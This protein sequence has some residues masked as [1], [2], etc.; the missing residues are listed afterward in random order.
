[1]RAGVPV[2][3]VPLKE[4]E[5]PDDPLPRLQKKKSV[6]KSSKNTDLELEGSNQV[7]KGLKMLMEKVS[8]LEDEVKKLQS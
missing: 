8:S 4:D 3:E 1:M 6:A 5:D 7:M 2:E